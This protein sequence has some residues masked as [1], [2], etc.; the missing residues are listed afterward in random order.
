MLNYESAYNDLHQIWS[1]LCQFSVD[2]ENSRRLLR[3]KYVGNTMSCS[4]L[5][6]KFSTVAGY[7]LAT[8]KK[9]GEIATAAG[10]LQKKLNQMV[11]HD[12]VPTSTHAGSVADS[13]SSPIVFQFLVGLEGTGHHLH[14]KLY[15]SCTR[16]HRPTSVSRHMVSSTTSAIYSNRCGIEKSRA[17]CSGR[18]L[19]LW[20]TKTR[21]SGG[22]K[23]MRV[24]TVSGCSRILSATSS[25]LKPRHVEVS[26]VMRP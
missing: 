7:D 4:R 10:R 26:R 19:A 24:P 20:P 6:N 16:A 2:V 1:S 18:Q 14:Q 5:A 17:R 23:K 9:S 21:A 11:S 15:K 3:Q 22:S 13:S 25:P 12:N 8:D